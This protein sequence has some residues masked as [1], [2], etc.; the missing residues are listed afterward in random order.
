MKPTKLLPTAFLVTALL[1]AGAVVATAQN[2]PATET[3]T[4]RSERPVDL[5]HA[6][7]MGD[8][9]GHRHGHHGKAGRHGGHGG[10][11]HQ[12]MTE[13]DTDGDGRLTRA[14]FDSFRAAQVE[15]AD[16]SGDGALNLEEFETL[17]NAFIRE[18]MVDAFQMLDADGDGEIA[19]EELDRSVNGMFD[20]M[21]RNGDDAIDRDDRGRR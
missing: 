3:D 13:A 6:P 11:L 21:D 17:F 14:E 19:P 7:S 5:R 15:G 2:Q 1:G 9:D 18:R 4:A 12:I 8:R 20:R 16:A 10:A